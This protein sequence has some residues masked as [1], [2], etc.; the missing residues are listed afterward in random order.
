MVATS[1]AATDCEQKRPTYGNRRPARLARRIPVRITIDA[2]P[3]NLMLAAG[4][5]ATV[6][7]GQ[8]ST[9]ADDLAFAIRFW[10][11]GNRF[12]TLVPPLLK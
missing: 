12:S 8:P 4:M 1:R 5:T 3:Q 6:A 10:T 11:A 9:I 7:V 2:P